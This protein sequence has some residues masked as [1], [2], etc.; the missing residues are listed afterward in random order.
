MKPAVLLGI[1]V[2][3]MAHL[4]AQMVIHSQP[5]PFDFDHFRF[6]I[7]AKKDGKFLIGKYIYIRALNGPANGLTRLPGATDP[8]SNSAANQSNPQNSIEETYFCVYDS[9]MN[10]LSA[11]KLPLPKEISG[12]HFISYPD[13][14]CLFYQYLQKHTTWCM[15]ATLDDQGRLLG[16]PVTIDT[17]TV[18]DLHYQS[19]IYTVINSADKE[20]I[21]VFK[22]AGRP[23]SGITLTCLSLDKD[24]HIR[25]RR[26][27][28]LTTAGSEYLSEFKLDDDGNLV[29]VGSSRPQTRE[30]ENQAL[31]F[32]LPANADT[33]QSD[34]VLT[35]PLYL[36]DIR[37]LIDNI[38]HRYILA[39]FYSAQPQGNIQGLFT[40]VREAQN[41]ANDKAHTLL[42]KNVAPAP[43]AFDHWYIEEM[44]LLEN[45]AFTVETQ[46]LD[47]SQ[48]ISPI[49]RWN[50]FQYTTQQ[51]ATDYVFFDPYEYDH[52]WPWYEWRNLD[53]YTSFI[54]ENALVAAFDSTGYPQWLKQ[55]KTPQ[56]ETR[57]L[58]IGFKTI[59]AGGLLYFVFNENI[60]HREYLTV[61][62]LDGKG[63]LN[64]DD[65]LHE[66]F[67][68]IDQNSDFTYYP[69]LGKQIDAREVILPCRK[70]RTLFLALL[71]L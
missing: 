46:Q 15:A 32:V 20:N 13:H 4:G 50:Y 34:Y 31:L 8:F 23:G 63:E 54:S 21:M 33:I 3:L 19:Q 16:A 39:S 36:D 25:R 29:F 22:Q 49:N 67:A 12:V 57:H 9:N 65:R 44:H 14:T 71:R 45:G 68:V 69:L 17:T 18:V 26:S 37:L 5:E 43:T 30:Q 11:T 10:Q 56:K 52:Y 27:N 42:L 2:S 40:F 1:F 28:T 64:S 61:Q 48:G 6:E 70:G 38:R 66:D 41:P 58:A 35:A 47:R 51:V 24:L 59:P 62:S 53:I 7:I 60:G 55:L